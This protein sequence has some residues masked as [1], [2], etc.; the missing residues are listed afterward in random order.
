MQIQNEAWGGIAIIWAG[1]RL[2]L[3][4]DVRDA[5]MAWDGRLMRRM[6]VGLA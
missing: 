5:W 6:P 1:G 3:L 4:V 2:T